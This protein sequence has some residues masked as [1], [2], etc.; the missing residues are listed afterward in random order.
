[1][2]KRMKA[3]RKRVKALPLE[4]LP[5]AISRSATT[6]ICSVSELGSL[7]TCRGPDTDGFVNVD[8][9]RNPNTA[10]SSTADEWVASYHESP[11]QAMAEFVNFLFRVC[12][13]FSRILISR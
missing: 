10:L 9:V 1:M 3:V 4:A 12:D 13:A 7:I 11:G 2:M 5:R 8:S 6:M